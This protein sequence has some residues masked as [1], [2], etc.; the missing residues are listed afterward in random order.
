[1]IVVPYTPEK[2]YPETAQWAVD[3][4][5]RMYDVSSSPDAYYKALCKWWAEDGDLLIV[6]H[7]ILPADGVVDEML[8]CLQPWCSSPYQLAHVSSALYSTIDGVTSELF[9]QKIVDHCLAGNKS[10]DTDA[11]GCTKFSAELKA[12]LPDLVIE[13]GTLAGWTPYVWWLND[14][15]ISGL[16]RRAVM[17][18]HLHAPSTHL[19]VS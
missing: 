1:L 17:T 19:S 2:L 4:N 3:N 9:S 13:S 6:E 16:L 8:A 5:A 11:L 7:D 10:Y 12:E 14:V 15:R 18:P